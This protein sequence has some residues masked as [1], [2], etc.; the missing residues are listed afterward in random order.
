MADVRE[1]V[2]QWCE[3]YS[4]RAFP[5]DQLLELASGLVSQQHSEDK[6]AAALFLQEHV[7]RAG[8]LKWQDAL[9]R[10]EAFFDD[11]HLADWNV[12]DW[13]CVKALW[14]LVDRDGEA[15]ARAVMSWS[16]ASNLWRGRASVVTFANVSSKGEGLFPGFSESLIEASADLIVRP[17]RFAKTGVGWV[18]R[19]LREA[20]PERVDA[21]LEVHLAAFSLESLR[22]LLRGAS[23]GEQR[24]LVARWKLLA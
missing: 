24:E 11:G 2:D 3:D 22:S 8:R 20:E 16:N 5:D 18:L 4:L 17:E 23:P 9:V 10:L 6:L 21:Y 7:I 14:A 13:F 12:V 15:C 19:G 1:A